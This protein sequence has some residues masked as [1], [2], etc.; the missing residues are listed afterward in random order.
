M[1]RQITIALILLSTL[2]NAQL[3]VFTN[4][5][6]ALGS[7]TGPA[8]PCKVQ[9]VGSSVFTATTNSI[10][11][12][13]MIRGN[14]SF[15]TP[16]TPDFT[17]YNSDQ[18]GIFHPAAN[19][20]GFTVSGSEQMR[21]IGS[22]LLLGSTTDD[23]VKLKISPATDQR[24][25]N[26]ILNHTSDYQYGIHIAANRGLTK[27][28]G[29]LL[30]GVEK[31]YVNGNGFVFM[32]GGYST[33]DASMKYNVKPIE[34]PLEKVLRLNGCTYNLKSDADSENPQLHM[35]LIAQEV[36]KVV[37]EVVATSDNGIKGVAYSNLVGLL[38]E[39]VK[40]QQSKID[41]LEVIVSDCCNN[42]NSGNLGSNNNTTAVPSG[43]LSNQGSQLYQNIPNP[44]TEST[45]IKY[46]VQQNSQ[47]AA[48]YIFSMNGNLLKTYSDLKKGEGEIAINGGEFDAGMYF[49]SLYV[50]EKEIETKKM[51]LTK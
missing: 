47:T 4:G 33:S 50:N 22:N 32:A 16:T 25:M 38:I 43:D 23:G 26:I 24:A 29:I 11:S 2:A 31:Y 12:A 18:T 51:V 27:V 6:V 39:A 10:T 19:V 45:R 37:P 46:T 8:W 41:S 40:E 15:S 34:K 7:T 3:K 20:I 17:W 49:Y 44:F 36:E 42:S 30:S 48:I 35:G 13:P 28:M 14:N 21:L 1:K 5:N 9:V